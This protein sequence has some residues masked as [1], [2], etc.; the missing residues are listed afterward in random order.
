MVWEDKPEDIADQCERELPILIE[1]KS[2]EIISDPKKPTHF[3]FEGNN[4]HTLYTPNFTHKKKIYFEFIDFVTVLN[5]QYSFC[6]FG[7]K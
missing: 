2:K 3:I 7:F 5:W 4:Y 6:L 1:D